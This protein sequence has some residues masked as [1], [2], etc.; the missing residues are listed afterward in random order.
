MC[1]ARRDGGLRCPIHMHQNIAAIRVAAKSSGLTRSQVEDLFKEVSKEGRRAEPLTDA[2]KEASYARIRQA[3]AVNGLTDEVEA[4]LTKAAENDRELTGAAGYAQRV[5]ISRA[6]ARRMA[7]NERLDEVADRNGLTRQEVE[8]VYEH[9]LSTFHRGRGEEYPE[10]YNQNT[11]RRAVLA[12]LPHD[13]TSVVALERLN[14]IGSTERRRRVTPVLLNNGS[15]L[16]SIGYSDG[17]LEVSFNSNPDVAYAYQNVPEELW[18]R[19][20]TA[21]RPGSVYARSIRSNVD[22]TYASAEE[23]EADAYAT[24][25]GSCGQFASRTGHTCPA[26]VRR[27]E[28]ADEG[29]TPE[30]IRTTLAEETTNVDARAAITGAEQE[31]EAED[32]VTAP[33]AVETEAEVAASDAEETEAEEAEFVLAAAS[34]PTVNPYVNGEEHPA[35]DLQ[36]QEIENY[37]G[38]DQYRGMLTTQPTAEQ[39]L[40]PEGYDPENLNAYSIDNMERIVVVGSNNMYRLDPGYGNMSGDLS[41]DDL[42]RIRTAPEDVNYI[43]ARDAE[44]NTSVKGAYDSKLFTV[45]NVYGRRTELTL[46]RR[47]VRAPVEQ[48]NTREER[49]AA[50]EVEAA[51]LT[52]L[53]NQGEAVQVTG[54]A[55]GTRRYI[56][57]ASAPTQPH[58][59]TGKVTELRRALRDNK[60][61]VVP[62]QVVTEYRGQAPDDQGFEIEYGNTTISGQVAVRRNASGALELV[63][64]GR[65]LKCDCYDY[66]TKYYCAHINY[67]ERHITNV[68]AQQAALPT[69]TGDGTPRNRFL[70]AALVNREDVRLIE[71]GEERNPYISFGQDIS[72]SSSNEAGYDA[73]RRIS[74]PVALRDMGDNPTFEQMRELIEFHSISN[75]VSYV[76]VPRNASSLR[77]A[78]K[79]TDTQIPVSVQF[80][81]ERNDNPEAGGYGRYLTPHVTGSVLYGQTDDPENAETKVRNLKCNCFDYQENYDCKHVRLVAGQPGMLFN[82]RSRASYPANPATETFNRYIDQMEAEQ[83]VVQAMNAN[84]ALSEEEARAEVVRIREERRLA[85]E[86][87]EAEER[88]RRRLEQERRIEAQRA[89]RERLDRMNSETVAA[90]AR[91]HENMLERWSNVEAPYSEN[92]DAFY[93]DYKAALARKA[94][95]EEVIAFRTENVTDGV[96]ADVEG[97]RRFGVEI[98]FDIDNHSNLRQI[99]I[100]LH[101]AGLTEDSYQAGYHAGAANGWNKWSFENDCTVAGEIVSPLMKDTPE[102][103]EQLRKVCEILERN[104]AKATTRTGSHVHVSTG[105]YGMSTAKHA[106]LIRTVNKNEDIMYRMASSPA[107]G[108]HRGTQ[109]CAPNTDD[110]H[111]EISSELAD[112][113]NVLYNVR[114][115]NHNTGMNFGGASNS[116]YKKSHVEFRM[117]D[118]SLDP[119]I[120]QQQVIMSV[121]TADLADRT[122]IQ[123]GSSKKSTERRETIG[124]NK[125]KEAQALGSRSSHTKET[126]NESNGKAQEFIDSLVRR[127]EDRA[128]LAALFAITNWQDR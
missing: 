22:Y 67:T 63:S 124:T 39:Q 126:F 53:I 27:Q 110:Q 107:R 114:G 77:A 33:V 2:E 49:D 45:G 104:G 34:V 8:A 28:L 21:D 55:T 18:N 103:W 47:G 113:H 59:T 30:E 87:R 86:R 43:V 101:A 5:I 75:R 111:D 51:R 61:A 9:H 91:Y 93:D 128:N 118:G 117:W 32:T 64:N 98:E 1:Q 100:E 20:A 31:P 115:N 50:R 69:A 3:A 46:T 52:S 24:R 127:P 71:R 76:S 78:L 108:R 74:T 54:N 42:A 90:T 122:V 119:A 23:A 7:L 81:R 19:L 70:T 6:N 102:D 13:V 97:A 85:E 112:G 57:D 48:F 56:F 58:V 10:E 11:R 12:G 83:E 72:F 62:V 88:E 29:L 99:G 15:H 120:I 123:N 68:L 106:E 94:A 40:S 17:R 105:S 4:D 92:D 73:R 95:G 79:R 65:S 89:E 38:I 16:H 96:C 82:S 60:V 26:R 36:G 14:N 66:R 109:W 116:T 44:G 41:E 80:S 121:A 37:I 35:A 84:P 125:R 25:C